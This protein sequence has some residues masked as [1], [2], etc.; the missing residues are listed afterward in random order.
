VGEPRPVNVVTGNNF[1]EALALSFATQVLVLFVMLFM[2]FPFA[3][4]EL[5]PYLFVLWIFSAYA[6]LYRVRPQIPI[7]KSEAVLIQPGYPIDRK[8]AWGYALLIASVAGDFFAVLA[9]EI[10]IGMNYSQFPLLHL[11]SVAFL[12]MAVMAFWKARLFCQ[13][14]KGARRIYGIAVP[15]PTLK[16]ATHGNVVLGHQFEHVIQSRVSRP[17]DSP[18]ALPGEVVAKTILQ[19][20]GLPGSYS[21]DL[22]NERNPHCVVL[23]TSGIGKTETVKTIVLRYWLAKKIPSLIVDWTNEYASFIRDIGGVVWTVPADFTINP[24][25]LLGLSPSERVAEFEEALFYSL[26]LTSLQASEVGKTVLEEYDRAGIV[27][28]DPS[29]W[30]RPTPTISNIIEIM[31]TRAET[32]YY[33]GTQFDSVSSTLRKFHPVL[34]IFGEEETDF[35]ETVRMIPTCINLS[36]LNDAAKAQVSYTILQRIYRQFE[37]LGFSDLR[38]LIVLD[39]AQLI[40]TEKETTGAMPQKPLPVRIVGLGRKYG[41]G[42][43]VSTHLASDV[44]EAIRAN[45]ASVFLLTLEEVNQLDYVRRWVNL[46]KPELEIYAELPLGGCF[47]KHIR[48]QYSA[49]VRVQ[50]VSKREFEAAKMDSA[51]I[52][53]PKAKPSISAILRPSETV[54][55]EPTMTAE[56]RLIQ[57]LDASEKTTPV[58]PFE[59]TPAITPFMPPPAVSPL[60]SKPMKELTP[61]ETRILDFLSSGPVTMRDLS[62]KFPRM[63]YRKMLDVLQDLDEQDLIQVERVANLDGKSTIY[64]AAL[65]DEWVKSEGIEH[66]AI[67]DVIER[68]LVNLGPV[69]Y[70]ATNPNYPDVGLEKSK[71]RTCIEVETGRKKLTPEGLGEWAKNVNER[72]RKLGYERVVVVVPRVAVERRYADACKRHNLEL[73]TMANLLANLSVRP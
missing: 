70:G 22:A 37:P 2:P 26:G 16:E 65:R 32:G 42:I 67:L 47:V 49:L 50:L 34:R 61:D 51:S 68:A 19:K 55:P 29:T 69:R 58:S 30:N 72:D 66:R 64:Y 44:P 41:F 39:E 52:K 53:I 48:E 38:L 7:S 54:S 23:G 25:K 4:Y 40:L 15:H 27:E 59:E 9:I 36:S 46:S 1:S 35:F 12:G 33:K 31:K 8:I 3:L 21:L 43:V 17:S 20:L 6:A 57:L 18:D 13:E 5:F 28:S 71:P 73:T 24:L 56:E 63:D 45:A 11:L 10:G 14:V 60:G 62:S